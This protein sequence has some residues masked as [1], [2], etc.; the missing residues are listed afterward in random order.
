M[1]SGRP[2]GAL[3]RPGHN[4][5]LAIR[6]QLVTVN[7]QVVTVRL[8]LPL[9]FVDELPHDVDVASGGQALRCKCCLSIDAD[10]LGDER[11]DLLDVRLRISA[12]REC[13]LRRQLVVR[14]HVSSPDR[15]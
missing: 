3:L 7:S 8:A 15:P 6:A 14:I 5:R 1:C 11:D 12:P 2:A 9:D 4:P 10:P 13:V